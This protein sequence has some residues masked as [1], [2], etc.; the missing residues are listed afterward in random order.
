M[1]EATE[2]IT[3]FFAAVMVAAVGYEIK[4]RQK[5]LRAIYNV[6]DSESK[7]ITADLEKLVDAG[8]L[9]PYSEETWV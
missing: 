4:R 6:L 1:S 7:Q 3:L 8:I 5:N 2:A 9:K